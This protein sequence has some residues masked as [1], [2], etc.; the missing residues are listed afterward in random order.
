MYS[1]ECHMAGRHRGFS[2]LVFV[3]SLLYHEA[4]VYVHHHRELIGDIFRVKV[5]D[6]VAVFVV[7]ENLNEPRQIPGRP[8]FFHCPG[9]I[10]A[11]CRVKR[12]V[13]EKLIQQIRESIARVA[14]EFCVMITAGD[15]MLLQGGILRAVNV[16]FHIG[17]ALFVVRNIIRLA[18]VEVERPG[19]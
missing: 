10:R 7:P 9:N 11:Q 4:H 1:H 3:C 18:P 13:R 15:Y 16:A 6:V 17:Q 12:R 8:Q 2:A 5:V 14:R 19:L